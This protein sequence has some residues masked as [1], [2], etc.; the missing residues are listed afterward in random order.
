MNKEMSMVIFIIGLLVF[1]VGG[2]YLINRQQKKQERLKAL[3]DLYTQASKS[4]N[5]S[6][7]LQAGRRY[8]S[9][10]RNG[11]LSIYDE[12]AITNDLSTI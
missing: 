12:R 8:Y 5:K 7:A 6:E 4:G 1:A 3:K 10:L 11:T 9:Y 2:F